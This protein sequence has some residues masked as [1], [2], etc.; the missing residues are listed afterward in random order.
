MR[1]F[2]QRMNLTLFFVGFDV[3]LKAMKKNFSLTSPN[4]KP[5][6]HIELLKGEINKY[7]A[8]ERRK[9]L[10]EGIDYWEFDCKCGANVESAVFLHVN[11]IGKAIE[12]LATSGAP[13][14]YVEIIVKAGVRLKRSKLVSD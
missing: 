11:E 9:A 10:P 12:S 13:S 8:R 7:I 2:L 3:I 4:H 1:K 6:R 5:D 14:A